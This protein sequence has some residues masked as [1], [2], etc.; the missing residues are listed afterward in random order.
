MKNN[1]GGGTCQEKEGRGGEVKALKGY[2]NG[3]GVESA[4]P[5]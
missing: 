1:E 4:Q 2:N 3:H 5:G